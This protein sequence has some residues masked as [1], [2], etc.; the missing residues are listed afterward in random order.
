MRIA[1]RTTGVVALA[2][3]AVACGGEDNNAPN[4]PAPVPI[5]EVSI[6]FGSFVSVKNAT[7]N[8]AIDTI[9]A[10]SKVRWTWVNPGPVGTH[11]IRPTLGSPNFPGSADLSGTGT[12]FTTTFTTPGTYD[13]ECTLHVVAFGMRGR[14]VVQ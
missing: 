7:S 5:A 8:P 1:R 13:Y 10:G 6:I 3:A 12:T 4:P 14:V 2:L 9:P 11:N